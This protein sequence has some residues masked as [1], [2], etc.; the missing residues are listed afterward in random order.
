MIIHNWTLP[1]SP[2]RTRRENNSTRKT[3]VW[4][5]SWARKISWM[6]KLSQSVDLPTQN[7]AE[8]TS[9][10]SSPQ[11]WSVNLPKRNERC[12][13]YYDFDYYLIEINFLFLP[14][15]FG[16]FENYFCFESLIRDY[17]FVFT[18]CKRVNCFISLFRFRIPT[19]YCC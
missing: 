8:L 6:E 17:S 15:F 11:Q 16:T 1:Y 2:L 13:M 3:V 9:K 14:S 7:W 4:I 12:V 10:D 19:F 18:N 5:S